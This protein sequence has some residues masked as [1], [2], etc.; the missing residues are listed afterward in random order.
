MSKA[1]C[2]NCVDYD[3]CSVVSGGNLCI[4]VYYAKAYNRCYRIATVGELI[5][6]NYN[7]STL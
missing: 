5:H 2:I 3:F 4:C 6:N 7:V 1:V